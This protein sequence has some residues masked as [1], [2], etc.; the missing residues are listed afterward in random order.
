MAGY[1]W[2]NQKQLVAQMLSLD[3][4]LAVTKQAFISQINRRNELGELLSQRFELSQADSWEKRFYQLHEQMNEQELFL[5]Q[6]TR[7]YTEGPMLENNLAVLTLLND[8]PKLAATLPLAQQMISHLTLWL[9]KHDRVFKN[10]EK[11]C[12]LYVGVEDG[13]KYPADFDQQVKNWL[14]E[15]Q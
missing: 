4:H 6:Q 1:H 12:L 13:A 14:V 2:M 7:A 8:N 15:N 9:N 11:M 5:C 10:S 3:K